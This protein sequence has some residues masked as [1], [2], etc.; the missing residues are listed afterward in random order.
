MLEPENS[1]KKSKI[2]KEG[3]VKDSPTSGGE[4]LGVYFEH[5]QAIKVDKEGN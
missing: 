3:W 5:S 1:I 2:K 4:G